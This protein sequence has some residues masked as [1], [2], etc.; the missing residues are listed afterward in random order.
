LNFSV[1]GRRIKPK[2]STVS[3]PRQVVAGRVYLVTRRCTQRQFLLRPDRETNNAFLYCLGYAAWRAGIQ[4]VAFIA[5]SNHYHAVLRDAEGRLPEFLQS[6]HRLLA[7]H[8]N[9]LR[10]RWEN[11]WSSEHSSVVE[12][13]GPDDVLAKTVYTLTNPVKDHLVERADHWPGAS[14]LHATIDGQ[15]LVASRPSRFFAAD[16]TMPKSVEVRCIRAPGL[17]H[18]SQDEYRRT[19]LDA[20]AQSELTAHK[21]RHASGRRLMGREA[22]LGQ[23]PSDRPDSREPRRLLNPR[24]AARDKG[25]RMEAIASMRAFHGAYAEA[26]AQWLLGHDPVFPPGTWWLHR[27]ARIRYDPASARAD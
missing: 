17:E 15:V 5:N 7:K 20:I 23:R 16:G 9:C 26:R 3:K 19:L 2:S 11:M 27:C 14:S 21:E 6:F 4:L 13:V 8:Q 18:L 22:V 25:P 1:N 10:G 12:L 24:V